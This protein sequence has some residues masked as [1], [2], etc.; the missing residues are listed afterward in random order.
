MCIKFEYQLPEF[1]QAKI[2]AVAGRNKVMPFATRLI[3]L[4]YNK[5]GKAFIGRKALS[6]LLGYENPTQ[7]AKYTTILERAGIISIGNSYKV[8]R[9]GKEYRLSQS[10]IEAMKPVQPQVNA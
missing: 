8:G 9:N 6:A 10:T 7:I 3:S 1:V 2:K 5:H 4:L